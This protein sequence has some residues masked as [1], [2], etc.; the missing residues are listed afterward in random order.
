MPT[1]DMRQSEAQRS[2]LGRIGGHD[3]GERYSSSQRK[4][5]LLWKT[6][7]ALFVAAAVAASAISFTGQCLRQDKFPPAPR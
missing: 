6:R 4:E 1:L 2:A 7:W 5:E 3:L